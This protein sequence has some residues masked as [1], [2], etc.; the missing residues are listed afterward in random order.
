MSTLD[1]TVL[2]IDFGNQVKKAPPHFSLA[3]P[4][5]PSKYLKKFFARGFGARGCLS[6]FTNATSL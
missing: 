1:M 6:V 2:S 3:P 4:L 5:D